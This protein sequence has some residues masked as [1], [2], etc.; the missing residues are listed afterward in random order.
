MRG[1]VVAVEKGVRRWLQPYS[2]PV[3]N[4]EALLSF[5]GVAKDFFAFVFG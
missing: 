3:F 4:A 2:P 1:V 5:D